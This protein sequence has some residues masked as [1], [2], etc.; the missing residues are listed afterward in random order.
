MHIYHPVVTPHGAQATVHRIGSLNL[1]DTVQVTVNSF[2]DDVAALPCWQDTH[3]IPLAAFTAS[4][5]PA[6]VNDY[7]ISA[8]GPLAGG[9]VIAGSSP[10]D[11]AKAKAIAR[12]NFDRA[13]FIDA[14][15]VTPAGVVDTTDVSI[16][17]IMASVTMA[18]I[19]GADF[20]I[21]WRLLDNTE[22]A[23]DA[24][25][26]IAVGVAVM[27]HVDGAMRHSWALKAQ[28]NAC[29]TTEEV[30]ALAFGGWSMVEETA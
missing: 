6:S 10:L 2:V 4:A 22:V 30:E 13:A 21:V 17:N 5:Y 1:R 8:Q 3:T 12:I 19:A 7:L 16:R 26:M 25:G 24:A 20:Q 27:A 29:T 23:L 15:C 28:V 11:Q 14:G 18:Q 9:V